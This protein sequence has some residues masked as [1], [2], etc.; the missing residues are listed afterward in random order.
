MRVVPGGKIDVPR[1]RSRQVQTRCNGPVEL[2]LIEVM[3]IRRS[4]AILICRS[5]PRMRM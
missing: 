5:D 4:L 2:A 1:L 3:M